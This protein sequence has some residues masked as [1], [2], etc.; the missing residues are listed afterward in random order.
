MKTC[1]Y[2]G[3]SLSEP[4]S[5]P[6]VDARSDDT[7]RYYDLVASPALIR[8]SLEDLLPWERYSAIEDFYVLLEELNKSAAVESND[9]AFTGP[10]ANESA[11]STKALECSG[12]VM[13]LF[14]AIEQNT[15]R[16]QMEWL[17][18]QL[19]MGLSELD[20][21]FQDGV[22]GTSIVPARYLALDSEEDGQLGT[23][24]MISF[25]AWGDSKAETMSN[26]GSVLQNLSKTLTKITGQL[27]DLQR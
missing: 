21:D 12:R 27:R 16:P 4:R 26:L 14:S 13:V 8:T 20:P 23:Q 9:C 25:W 18:N 17:K 22:V 10:A 15:I 2:A 24:L 6:W 11:A 19:H 1:E 7:C 5:H 3:P